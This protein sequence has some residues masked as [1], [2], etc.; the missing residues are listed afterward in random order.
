MA[1]SKFRETRRSAASTRD[2]AAPRLLDGGEDHTYGPYVVVEAGAALEAT[3]RIPLV[4]AAGNVVHAP[5]SR[6]SVRDHPGRAARGSG[7]LVEAPGRRRNGFTALVGVLLLV[8]L[9]GLLLMRVL[10]TSH[11]PTATT[12]AGRAE[13]TRPLAGAAPGAPRAEPTAVA[14]LSAPVEPA[15]A[16][17][18]SPSRLGT[19]P[20]TRPTLQP[21]PVPRKPAEAAPDNSPVGT[22]QE[23]Y[24]LIDARRYAD[25]YALMDAH[26]RSL[27]TPSEYASWFASKVSIK[28]I[29]VD[30]VSETGRPG[31]RSCGSD[32]HGSGRGTRRHHPRSR[33]VR[34]PHGGWCAA[35]RPGDT[36]LDRTAHAPSPSE[37]Q[38]GRERRNDQT[39]TRRT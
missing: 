23:H 32:K 11:E 17:P 2:P 14:T 34:P 29:A 37:G 16:A 39:G 15:K 27:N 13:P 21:T 12:A 24:A 38:F 7:S 25:G 10:A 18:A 28:P 36:T 30:L 19:A 4:A 33:A 35:H 22:I 26:L 5:P 8:D 20:T 3:Q 9:A 31:G 6:R 1:V